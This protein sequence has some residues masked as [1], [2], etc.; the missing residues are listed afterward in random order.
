MKD[1]LKGIETQIL[2]GLNYFKKPLPCNQ[3]DETLKKSKDSKMYNL[4]KKLSAMI[5]LEHLQTWEVL[6]NYLVYAFRGPAQSL[7][8]ILISESKVNAVL[9]DMFCFYCRER[10]FL[11][12]SL[13]HIVSKLEKDP[14]SDVYKE[15]LNKLSFSKLYSSLSKQLECVK[16]CEPPEIT[17]AGSICTSPLVTFWM[18]YNLLEQIQ[19]VKLLILVYPHIEPS[20]KHIDAALTAILK[21]GSAKRPGA[22]SKNDPHRQ[23]LLKVLWDLEAFHFIQLLSL[24]KLPG[25]NIWTDGEIFSKMDRQ[26]KQSYRFDASGALFAAWMVVTFLSPFRPDDTTELL[27]L[28]T[29]VKQLNAFAYLDHFL[30]SPTIKDEPAISKIAH[31]EVHALLYLAVENFGVDFVRDEPSVYAL[32]ATLVRDEHVE[33]MF[34]ENNNCGLIKL[35][36]EAEYWFPEVWQPATGILGALASHGKDQ[37]MKVLARLNNNMKYCQKNMGHIKVNLLQSNIFESCEDVHPLPHCPEVVIPK[38]TRC[39]TT[40]TSECEIIHWDFAVPFWQVLHNDLKAL[41]QQISSQAASASLRATSFQSYSDAFSIDVRNVDLKDRIIGLFKFSSEIL[42]KNIPVLPNDML[43]AI[44]EVFSIMNKNYVW[45]QESELDLLVSCM[46]MSSC[47]L[48]LFSTEMLNILQSLNSLPEVDHVVMT[49]AQCVQGA[50]YRGSQVKSILELVEINN[51]RFPFLISYL[52][53]VHKLFEVEETRVSW[54]SLAGLMF[55]L[56]DV[57][58]HY[59]SW[60]FAD[61]SERV[62]VGWLCL[63]TLHMSLNGSKQQLSPPETSLP[64]DPCDPDTPAPVPSAGPTFNLIANTCLYSLLNKDAGIALIRIVALGEQKLFDMVEKFPSWNNGKSALLISTVHY[65]LSVLNRIIL[66]KDVQQ[67]PSKLS[68]TEEEI[69]KE[70]KDTDR[71]HCVLNVASYIHH[72]FNPKLR[73]L[74]CRL[75]TRFADNT[76]L[77]LM[78]CTGLEPYT[79]RDMFLQPLCSEYESVQLKVAILEFI[80]KCIH[81]QASLAEAFLNVVELKECIS[82]G[83]DQQGSSSGV[84]TFSLCIICGASDFLG[85]AVYHATID[86]VH[87]LWLE[88]CSVVLSYLRQRKGFWESLCKPLFEEEPR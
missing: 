26:L 87:A 8:K 35:L 50:Y 28:A 56:R 5:K 23:T 81:R 51:G 69:Y 71:F 40:T 75:L 49:H 67:D 18:E 54:L 47:L 2:E 38:G 84:L 80:T 85:D 59:Q 27:S 63:Q 36:E 21:S 86:V 70:P 33:K 37:C 88:Q 43:I 68:P 29:A 64:R 62:E 78:L 52:Q 79:I 34:W 30:N 82:S 83:K 31:Q 9:A 48:G 14:H 11:L 65:A 61:E 3:D 66:Y 60:Y 39:S 41:Q 19:L 46:D 55:V 24:E 4:V 76:R 77:S 58:P 10:M 6:S 72:S 74:A 25:E 22:L 17:I 7:K 73:Y 1:Q 15:F 53:F 16:L 13:T 12:K 57:L 32:T 42:N 20:M 44:E 45:R